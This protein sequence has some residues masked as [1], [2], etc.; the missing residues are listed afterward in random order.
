MRRSALPAALLAL[1][2]AAVPASAATLH[3]KAGVAV[4]A[5]TT[6][7][8]VVTSF[9]GTKIFTTL[10][11]PDGG[12]PAPLVL[13]TH[14]W[15][16]TGETTLTGTAKKLVDAGYAVMTWDERGFGQSGG[17]VHID[18]PLYEGKDASALIDWAV[19]NKVV[20]VV[21][22]DPV[23][24]MTGGSYAGGIQTATAAFDSRIDAIAPEISWSDLRYSLDPGRVIKVGWVSLLYAAGNTA[25]SGGITGATG[26]AGPQTGRYASDLDRAYLVGAATNEIDSDS[27]AFL[28]GSSLDHYDSTKKLLDVPTLVM[29]GSVDTLFNLA[30]GYG[31]YQHAKKAGAPAKFIAFCGGHVS[32]PSTYTDAKDRAHLDDAI[33]TWFQRYLKGDKTAK[34][35]APV[36][37]RTNV[38][39]VFH[40]A[41]GFAPSNSTPLT[42]KVDGSLL[43]SA[44]PAQEALSSGG[45]GAV[46]TGAPSAAG[47]P[48]ATTSTVTQATQDLDLVGLPVADLKVSGTG[49]SV[50]LFVKLVDRESGVVVNLQEAPMRVDG[51]S[52]TPQAVHVRMPGVAYTLVKGHH[53][54]VQVT[55]ASSS[56]LNARVPA[57][58]TV[59]GSVTVPSVPSGHA[60]K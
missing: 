59:T 30:D 55:T 5:P 19:A 47:D 26:P 22:G 14:G 12:A 31:I 10:F 27:N 25:L 8:Q 32:C 7:Q 16:G 57:Q 38:G 1:A 45:T 52:A 39:G 53:L 3:G 41:D 50:H 33:L 29:N 15:G 20:T 35:G 44:A 42:G 18:N 48:R 46:T 23:V 58:V 24:G 6:T 2:V 4:A 37:Y 34:T 11:R 56:Y 13:R 54:D 43:S 9:D 40:D 51:L 21:D 36:E 17:E 49:S 60:A 28:A